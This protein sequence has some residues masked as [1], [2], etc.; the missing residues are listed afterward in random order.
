[1]LS[2]INERCV[3]F[4]AFD[5]VE[6]G[7]DKKPPHPSFARLVKA[8]EAE[9]IYSRADLIDAIGESKFVVNNWVRRG[10]SMD[11]AF[12]VQKKLGISATW[13]R[14]ESGPMK[15]GENFPPN[16]QDNEQKPSPALIQH[17]K[18]AIT[19]VAKMGEFAHILAL[20]F[21]QLPDDPALRFSVF[22]ECD[23]IIG[24]AVHGIAPEPLHT[25]DAPHHR[26]TQAG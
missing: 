8:S 15:L 20:R 26:S 23:Q 16:S 2:E 9:G 18:I 22:S 10:V 14:D 4:F 1:M 24:R 17:A 25:Q 19:N 11:G 7:M 21:E 6:C 12:I 13:I 5:Y 3:I